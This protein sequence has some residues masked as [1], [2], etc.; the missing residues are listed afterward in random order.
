MLSIVSYR[1][2]NLG[3]IGIA[4]YQP[5]AFPP[6]KPKA[7]MPLKKLALGSYGYPRIIS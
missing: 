4:A 3:R 1:I 6:G 7:I 2:K 5:D